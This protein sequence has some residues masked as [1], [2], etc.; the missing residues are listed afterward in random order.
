MSLQNSHP[1][2]KGL[3]R[4]CRQEGSTKRDSAASTSVTEFIREVLVP[5]TRCVLECPF[6]PRWETT[7]PPIKGIAA[8]VIP[9]K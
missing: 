9:L 2:A 1:R 6:G 3:P 4:S 5:P 8:R 7:F